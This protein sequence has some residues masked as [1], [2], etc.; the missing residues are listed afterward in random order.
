[1]V[2]LNYFQTFSSYRAVNTIKKQL[3]LYKEISLLGAFEKL[4]KATTS[5]VMSVGLPASKEQLGFR[6]TDFHEICYIKYANPLCEQNVETS[7][8][9]NLLH[10]GYPIFPGGNIGQ[11]MALNTNTHLAPK[12]Q[13]YLYSPSGPSWPVLEPNWIFTLI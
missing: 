6:W 4:R 13:L 3:T 10:N 7:D 11:G 12:L 9:T 8:L 5:Y 2:K 1:M